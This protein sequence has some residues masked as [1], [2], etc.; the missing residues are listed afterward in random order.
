AFWFGRIF[1][2][3]PVSTSSENALVLHP[4]VRTSVPLV[5]RSV[6][7]FA[8]QVRTLTTE[9]TVGSGKGGTN[10]VV[11]RSPSPALGHQHSLIDK[12]AKSTGDVVGMLRAHA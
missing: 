1:F 4:Q 9:D 12:A 10:Q 8:E 11:Q 7:F 5:P 2:D 6:P 3:E